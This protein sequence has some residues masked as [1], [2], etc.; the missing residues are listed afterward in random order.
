MSSYISFFHAALQPP[1][2]PY[3]LTIYFFIFIPCFFLNIAYWLITTWYP[4]LQPI[5]INSQQTKNDH[6]A[7]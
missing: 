2:L 4:Y 1:N 3:Y 5:G 6:I 7:P